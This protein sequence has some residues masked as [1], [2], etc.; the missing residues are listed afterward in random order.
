MI[1]SIQ[2]T[3]F[4]DQDQYNFNI[5][6]YSLYTN[7]V[8]SFHRKGGVA[9]YISDSLIHR[10]VPID[11]EINAVAAEVIINNKPIL[12]ASVYIPP[13]R[14]SFHSENLRTLI[15]KLLR[16]GPLLLMGDLNA[17]HQLWGCENNS[18][19]GSEVDAIFNDFELICLNDG[20]HTFLSSSNGTRSAI[21]LAASS[22]SLSAWFQFTVHDDLIFSDHFPILLHFTF[23]QSLLPPPR[24]PCWSMK[25]ADWACFRKAVEDE[26]EEMENNDISDLLSIIS[27][28][29][30]ACIPITGPH[31]RRQATPW[32]TPECSHAVAKRKRA[33]RSYQKHICTE[34][35]VTYLIASRHCR[36]VLLRAKKNILALF[37]F[38]L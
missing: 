13:D 27:K 25:R 26:A 29:A 6:G 10:A 37:C 15:N 36:A 3:H 24:I 18:A 35:R 12:I 9:L 2:E 1:G 17:H 22:P 4:K 19:R 11:T 28:A 33:L 31:R 16:G 14:H 23:S 38:I 21:D 32:W 5:A 8:N 34:T 30:E 7:N 20:N